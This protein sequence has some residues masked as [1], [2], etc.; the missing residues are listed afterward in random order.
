MSRPMPLAAPVTM[1]MRSASLIPRRPG[2]R[3][4][5]RPLA[6]VRELPPEPRE[7]RFQDLGLGPPPRGGAAFRGGPPPPPAAP[8][9]GD[10]PG[11]GARL[12]AKKQAPRR[13]RPAGGDT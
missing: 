9:V 7:R 6:H 2:A 11:G 5:R 13:G 8:P 3:G 12:G 10:H 4:G 1:A